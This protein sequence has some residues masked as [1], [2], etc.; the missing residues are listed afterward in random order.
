MTDTQKFFISLMDI[1]PEN[2]I[3]SLDTSDKSLLEIIGKM[4][5]SKVEHNYTVE[6]YLTKENKISLIKSVINNH[7]E[8]YI[9]RL[10]V[11]LNQERL[12]VAYDGCEIG[13]M[14]KKVNITHGFIKDFVDT[15]M[16]GVV[17]EVP[18]A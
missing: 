5:N 18:E 12:F 7:S 8:E 2:A 9:H 14:S 3:L 17:E 6:L 4:E 13:I 16:C 15:D 11:Y 10:R 1:F